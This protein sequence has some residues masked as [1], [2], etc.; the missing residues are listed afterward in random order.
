MTMNTDCVVERLNI[1][2]NQFALDLRKYI[3]PFLTDI[4][5][6]SNQKLFAGKLTASA[7]IVCDISSNSLY[8]KYRELFLSLFIG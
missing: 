3:L 4:Y 7:I 1:F 2:K 6:Y 5:D 8:F